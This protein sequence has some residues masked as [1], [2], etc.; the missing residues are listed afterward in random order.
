MFMQLINKAMHE[1]LYKGV[2]VYL[3]DMLICSEMKDEHVKLIWTM[4][5]KLQGT[6]MYAK[7][8]KC[9]FYKDKIEY[10]GYQILQ[11]VWK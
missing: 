8:S 9:E 10:L 4:L 2:L 6:E 1:H 3:D 5:K 11:E 7:L